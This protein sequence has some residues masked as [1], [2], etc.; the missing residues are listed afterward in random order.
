MTNPVKDGQEEEIGRGE[1]AIT[2]VLYRAGRSTI[3]SC[4]WAFRP[5]VRICHGRG[6]A[7]PLQCRITDRCLFGR[8][9]LRIGRDCADGVDL[10]LPMGRE[11]ITDFL[12][13]KSETV[14]HQ[15]A[16]LKSSEILVL[17]KPGHPMVKNRNRLSALIPI[18]ETFNSDELHS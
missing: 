18:V 3:K 14:S 10:L 17:L 11:D 7:A 1:G 12:V 15:L 16:L 8:L 13:L 9:I 2:G 4:A 6:N 5:F